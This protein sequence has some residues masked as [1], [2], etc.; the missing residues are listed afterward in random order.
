MS[1]S[2]LTHRERL[3]RTLAGDAVDR[4]PIALWR[5]FPVDDQ[6]PAG[7][8]AAIL[9]FQSLYD[10]DL[11][12]VTPASSFC[13]KDWGVEDEWR[14]NPEG[15]REYTT[16]AIRN[17]EDWARLP[18]LPPTRGHLGAQLKC[19]QILKKNCDPHT[20]IIQTIFSPLAQAKNLVGKASLQVHLRR[21]PALIHAGL[22]EITRTTIAFIEEAVITGIDGIF[23]AV[24]HAQYGQLSE[25]EFEEFGRNYDL[26][27]L[28]AAQ[29]LW[30]NMGHI[31]GTDIMFEP[32]SQYPVQII[33][34]HDQE[35]LPD[36]AAAQSS[37][38]GAV[39]GGLRQ[40]ETLVKGTPAQVKKEAAAAIQATQGRRFILGTGCVVPVTAPHGNLLAARQSVERGLA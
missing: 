30:L 8:A 35:T 12:K 29:S 6:T 20:P 3:E 32:V 22:E 19:L 1:I 9:N 27:V 28:Q 38:P 23:Y 7:L 15:V 11:I 10:F 31:H 36:L 17:P 25:L 14:G 34:W 21:H 4:V 2:S 40:W 5:H 24:Q 26:Q 37:F 18:A 39:C 16:A 33:N 13:I